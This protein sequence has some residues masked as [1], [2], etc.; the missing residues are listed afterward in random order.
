MR[1]AIIALAL[2]AA[3]SLRAHTPQPPDKAPLI[4]G[5]DLQAA[6]AYCDS[7]PIRDP[8][9]IYVWPEKGSLVLIR[10]CAHTGE[11]PSA[12]EII[13][14][15]SADILLPP[16]QVTGYIYPS[17][18]AE[19]FH[20]Y[21]YGDIGRDGASSPK[22]MA[23]THE[24]MQQSFRF[25]GRKTSVTLNPLSLIPHLRS[26]LRIKTENPADAIPDGL[27]RIYPAPIPTHDNPAIP[28]PRYF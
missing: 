14:L 3:L 12:Y 6:K 24:P 9:G 19:D 21:I 28:Y 17:P 18:T 27:R 23:A 20:L 22:H 5:M 25:K 1:T 2:L 10:T 11:I 15:E 8:E 16:G 7:M 26:L 4:H 13:N